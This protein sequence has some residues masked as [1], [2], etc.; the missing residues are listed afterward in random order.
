MAEK[1]EM[2][3]VPFVHRT[4]AANAAVDFAAPAVQ[5]K[6]GQA[7]TTFFVNG[8]LLCSTSDYFK[9]VLK[10]EW[11][12]GKRRVVEL[13]TDAADSFNAYMNWL[14]NRTVVLGY[15]DGQNPLLEINFDDLTDA[16]A[17]GDKLLDGDFKDAV[18]DAVVVSM[19]T[20][21]DNGNCVLPGAP[22]AHIYT[23]PNCIIPEPE[24]FDFAAPALV[25]KVGSPAT[26][27]FVNEHLIC[28]ASMY[29]A[30]AMKQEWREGRRRVLDLCDENPK[31][32]NIYLNWLYRKKLVI[33]YTEDQNAVE[34]SKWSCLVNA[35]IL[36]DKL[37]D[38]DFKDVVT[39]AMVLLYLTKRHAGVRVYPG[40]SHRVKLY[41]N[42]TEG[43]KARKLFVH[44]F[45]AYKTPH[46]EIERDPKEF[47]VDLTR[48]L[49]LGTQ[50]D[51]E[52]TA[53]TCLFHEHKDGVCYRSKLQLQ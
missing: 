12:E 47:L 18:T 49:M 26:T 35:Y 42:T 45:A 31:T 10:Q 28:N 13:P 37:I 6:V 51:F 30:T 9:T 52:K 46:A 53:K 43:S 32:F 19:N 36:G 17:L 25:V 48:S 24:A 41:E 21:D 8:D 33:G 23:L 40:C 38:P 39:D 11:R 27:Y 7:A 16:Y 1:H 50:E 29:F 22:D 20:K 34:H 14:H 44:L 4:K 5:V 3:S 15:N 2:A